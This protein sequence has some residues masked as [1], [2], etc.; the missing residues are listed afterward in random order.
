M[1]DTIGTF[2]TQVKF[3]LLYKTGYSRVFQLLGTLSFLDR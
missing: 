3:N 1:I 2:S